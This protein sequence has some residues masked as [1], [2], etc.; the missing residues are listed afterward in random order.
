MILVDSSFLAL[1]CFSHNFV[2][3]FFNL[4]IWIWTGLICAEVLQ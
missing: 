1:I 3:C 2:N 4:W